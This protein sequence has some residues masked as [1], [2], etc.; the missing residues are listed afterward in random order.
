MSTDGTD[1]VRTTRSAGTA[2]ALFRLPD[3]ARLALVLPFVGALVDVHHAVLRGPASGDLV[4]RGRLV[5]AARAPFHY[6]HLLVI[7]VD[8]ADRGRYCLAVPLAQVREV[9]PAAPRGALEP[10][11]QTEPTEEDRP[12]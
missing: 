3:E 6:S 2:G 8:T 5:C 9:R 7:E 4:Y 11:T 10:T 1:I 12:T